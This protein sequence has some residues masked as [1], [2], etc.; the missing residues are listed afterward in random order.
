M[1]FARK[2]NKI[3]EFDMIRALK[4]QQN[5]GILHN[6]CPAHVWCH[7]SIDVADVTFKY[8]THLQ[9]S[10]TRLRSKFQSFNCELYVPRISEIKNPGNTSIANKL[11]FVFLPKLETNQTESILLTVRPC[12]FLAKPIHQLQHSFLS[13]KYTVV[14][15]QRSKEGSEASTP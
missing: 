13:V 6:I 7:D 9:G 12:R 10:Y 11:G 2:V 4:N 1:I 15:I 8:S 5:A 14:L 3:P